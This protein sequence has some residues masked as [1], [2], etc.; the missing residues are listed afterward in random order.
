MSRCMLSGRHSSGQELI[1]DVYQNFLGAGKTKDYLL[2]YCWLEWKDQIDKVGWLTRSVCAPASY[3]ELEDL[4]TPFSS[5]SK[6]KRGRPNSN[7]DLIRK[8]G[9]IFNNEALIESETKKM[10]LL[11]M[12]QSWVGCN[13]F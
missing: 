8:L 13:T 1:D 4:S 10:I 6:K 12:E 2:F 5:P 3:P 9:P 7:D 11:L